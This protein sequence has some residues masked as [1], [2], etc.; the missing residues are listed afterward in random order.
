MSTSFFTLLSTQFPDLPWQTEV[1]L[2]PFTYMKIGGP[3]EVLWE[4]HVLNTFVEVIR[5]C[6]D[7]HIPLT[8]LGGSSN[9]LIDDA[10]LR[11]LVI[12]NRCSQQEVL[13][14][15]AA[16]ELLPVPL[17]GVVTDDYGY[18]MAES[19]QKTALVVG[20]S[21]QHGL[22][23]LEPFLGVPGTLG[24]AIFNNS[25]YTQELIGT[26]VVAVEVLDTQGN[27]LW[28]SQSECQ[29]GYDTSRFHQSG[30]IILRALFGLE[31]G[32][33]QVSQAK[34]A[35]ATVKRATTQ[36]L[37]TANSGCMFRNVEVPIE[38]QSEYNGQ[39]HLSAGWLIDQAGLK[40]LQV[41]GA[42]VS[43]KHANFIV[44]TGTAT[45]ADVQKLVTQIQE[46][47][48]QKYN[49]ELIPEVFFLTNNQ[50][51]PRE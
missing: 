28:L 32:S 51:P 35:E 34:I 45:S 2:A 3:A 10:G 9:V 11:G 30:E 41:G 7:R 21:V 43:D 47:I 22:T 16:R 24:G 27:R 26:Y 38:R 5:F 25:H 40:G 36:P 6:W 37:G 14:A 1:D 12:L 4:A 20:F 15:A 17:H 31:R 46:K 50:T 23:G 13:P 48:R 42:I 33:P 8:I 49:V 44:N 19:G 18:V 29:F 39:T